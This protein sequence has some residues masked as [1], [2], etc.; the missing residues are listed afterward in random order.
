LR[1]AK[2]I[3]E[4]LAAADPRIRPDPPTV[5]AVESLTENGVNVVLQPHVQPADYAAVKYD[6]YE[7]VKLRFDEAAITIAAPQREVRLSP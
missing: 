7:R 1:L 6:L 3:L 2:Q 5:V 4:E